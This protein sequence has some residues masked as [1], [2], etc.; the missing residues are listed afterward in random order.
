MSVHL[1]QLLDQA[2]DG[3]LIPCRN[4]EGDVDLFARATSG[5]TL[6]H[7]AVGRH[8]ADEVKYLI[9]QGLDIN[10]RGDFFG[11]PLHLAASSGDLAMIGMLMMLGADKDIPDHLGTLPLEEF[12]RFIDR[13][14]D[15]F[16]EL[17]A[18]LSSHVREM[19]RLRKSGVAS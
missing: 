14:A 8:R 3:Y 5:D 2:E 19:E 1:H 18:A 7:V 4:E 10:A 17:H 11:T 15:T 13:Q 9:D 16:W 6:L 12:S